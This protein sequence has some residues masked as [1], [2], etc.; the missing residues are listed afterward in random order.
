MGVAADCM[1]FCRGVAVTGVDGGDGVIMVTGGG[2]ETGVCL[3]LGEGVTADSTG[4][5]TGENR[6]V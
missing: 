5:R 1:T 6:G 3:V 2:P 4:G